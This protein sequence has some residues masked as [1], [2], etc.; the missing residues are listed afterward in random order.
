[1]IPGGDRVE[2][3]VTLQAIRNRAAPLTLIARANDLEVGRV[4]LA[5]DGEAGWHSLAFP[6]APWPGGARLV[7]EV[8]H[9]DATPQNGVKVD[10]VDL[11]WR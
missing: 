4:T 3:A 8:P 7:L 5:A 1:M 6:V 2:I 9:G 10:R 11:R